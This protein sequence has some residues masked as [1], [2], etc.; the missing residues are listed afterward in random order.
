MVDP[1]MADSEVFMSDDAKEMLKEILNRQKEALDLNGQLVLINEKMDT[2]IETMEKKLTPTGTIA[3]IIQNPQAFI[4]AV[5]IIVFA[6]F[7]GMGDSL[8]DRAFG[9]KTVQIEEVLKALHPSTDMAADPSD[10]EQ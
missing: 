4:A 8:M 6:L 5:M 9:P 1:V 7:L 10:E 2:L 3:A